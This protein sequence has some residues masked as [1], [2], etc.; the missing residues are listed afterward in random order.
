M[1]ERLGYN[2]LGLETKGAEKQAFYA[3]LFNEALHFSGSSKDIT[4]EAVSG[5]NAYILAMVDGGK[6]SLTSAQ[7]RRFGP[8]CVKI[9]LNFTGSV[10]NFGQRTASCGCA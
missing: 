1:D 5:G 7:C 10:H 6:Y 4:P 2:A 9:A 3:D 8:R